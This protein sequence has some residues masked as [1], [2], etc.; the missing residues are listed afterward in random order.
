LIVE[1]SSL[2]TGSTRE[3]ARKVKQPILHKT[4]IWLCKLIADGE[5]EE[6]IGWQEK[7]V[8]NVAQNY[9]EF[10]EKILERYRDKKEFTLDPD[11]AI[12]AEIKAAQAE[13]AQ[14]E[15]EE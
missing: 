4:N 9:Q 11:A 14:A 5:F 8:E 6:A 2:L 13:A 1:R 15:S 7:V 12:E 10:A 3:Q